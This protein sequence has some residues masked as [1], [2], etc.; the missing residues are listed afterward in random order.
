MYFIYE[1][2][3]AAAAAAE[4]AGQT[5]RKSK[6]TVT[7]PDFLRRAKSKSSHRPTKIKTCCAAFFKRK[8]L[9]LV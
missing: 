1:M 7:A 5:T 6:E 8:R 3:A 2:A 9:I 4:G